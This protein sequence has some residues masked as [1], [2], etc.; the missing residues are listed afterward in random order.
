[1]LADAGMPLGNQSVL[2]KGIN[3]KPEIMLELVQK[4]LEIRVKPYYIY[5]A[6]LV[7]GTQHFRTKVKVGL[8]IMR[9][10]RGFTSGM[11]VPDFIVDLPGGGGKVPLLPEYLVECQGAKLTFRNYKNELFTYDDL[12][13]A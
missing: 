9:S 11:A 2:L 3:D 10:I 1:M 6:D 12:A 8:D 5:Q 13:E 7:K 4:L